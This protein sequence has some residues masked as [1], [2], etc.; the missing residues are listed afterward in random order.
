MRLCLLAAAKIDQQPVYADDAFQNPV[1]WAMSPPKTL[2]IRYTTTTQPQYKQLDIMADAATP[3]TKVTEIRHGSSFSAESPT[4]VRVVTAYFGP[5]GQ[6]R[7]RQAGS[8]S[9]I[10]HETI[11]R[12]EFH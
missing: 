11:T 5:K 2:K 4:K 12:D 9:V 10:R 8:L 6:N 7:P 3:T 1:R